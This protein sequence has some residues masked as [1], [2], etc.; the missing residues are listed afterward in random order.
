MFFFII[1]APGHQDPSGHAVKLW[2]QH[3]HELGLVKSEDT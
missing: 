2:K 3:D 1:L